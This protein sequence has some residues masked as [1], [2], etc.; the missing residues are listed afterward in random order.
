MRQVVL[1][2][3]AMRPC[4]RPSI[5]VLVNGLCQRGL[6]HRPDDGVHLLASLEDHD[7][8]DAP[9][10]VVCGHV[11]ALIRV[12]L[13]A[14]EFPRVVGGELIDQRSDH[15]AGP[16]PGC[17]EVDEHWLRALQDLH[18][19]GVVVDVRHCSCLYRW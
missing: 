3:T 17:P 19:E 12:E 7:S 15:A 10:A 1:P 14:L 2:C 11:W 8:G 16:T 9:D 4:K 6:G 18:L 13:D 5:D